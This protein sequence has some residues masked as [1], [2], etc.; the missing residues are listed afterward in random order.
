MFTIQTNASLRHF[1]MIFQPLE[2]CPKTSLKVNFQKNVIIRKIS[3]D[4]NYHHVSIITKIQREKF[5][6]RQVFSLYLTI[7]HEHQKKGDS[8]LIRRV[9]I[10]V[11]AFFTFL[12]YFGTYRFTKSKKISFTKYVYVFN[13]KHFNLKQFPII[14]TSN[15]KR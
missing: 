9:N 1:L 6:T 14:K 11:A 3:C 5:I 2:R 12:I 7:L 4:C 10:F 15:I 13:S 8:Y